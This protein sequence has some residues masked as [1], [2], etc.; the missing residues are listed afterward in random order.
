MPTKVIKIQQEVFLE[1][2]T[3]EQYEELLQLL[4]SR[5]TMSEFSVYQALGQY[6][7]K[8]RDKITIVGRKKKDKK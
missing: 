5:P 8:K 7:F 4:Q 2:T 1:W 3:P 6:L